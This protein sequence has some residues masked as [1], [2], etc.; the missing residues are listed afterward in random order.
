MALEMSVGYSHT[1]YSRRDGKKTP[2]KCR[3]NEEN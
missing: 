1:L 3:N 2:F